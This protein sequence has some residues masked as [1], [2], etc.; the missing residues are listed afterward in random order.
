MLYKFFNLERKMKQDMCIFS[1]KIPFRID[2]DSAGYKLSYT[3]YAKNKN[4]ALESLL[5]INRD[6]TILDVV[7]LSPITEDESTYMIYYSS[8]KKDYLRGLVYTMVVK[9][10]TKEEALAKCFSSMTWYIGKIEKL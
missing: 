8:N 3:T 6:V 2:Y 1:K 9:A 4:S 10:K 5:K 7:D